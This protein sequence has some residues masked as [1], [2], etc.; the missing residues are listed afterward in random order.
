MMRMITL[1]IYFSLAPGCMA[2]IMFLD[3]SIAQAL[4]PVALLLVHFEIEF[5]FRGR[6]GFG[7][8][9]F[10][11]LK[12]AHDIDNAFEDVLNL[13]VRQRPAISFLHRFDNSLLA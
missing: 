3:A 7:S 6:S 1:S 8:V 4:S 11:L 12:L 10:L 5:R 13:A 2:I 9:N